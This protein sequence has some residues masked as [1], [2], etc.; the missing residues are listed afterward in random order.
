MGRQGQKEN[1]P[2]RKQAGTEAQPSIPKVERGGRQRRTTCRLPRVLT[3]DPDLVQLPELLVVAFPWNVVPQADGAQGDETE[4]KRFEEVPVI[5]QHGEHGGRD[6][7]EAGHGDESQQN[8]VDD[9]HHLLGEAP[10]YVEVED[11]SAG[12]MHGDTLDHGRQEE[13]GER[14]ANDGVDDAEGLAPI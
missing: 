7:E 10:A 8:G 3:R 4:V 14:D 12:D 1:T 9:G 5:L 2:K 13:E 11:R 6:E